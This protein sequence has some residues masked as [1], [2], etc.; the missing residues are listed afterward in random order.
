MPD[1]ISL[2]KGTN[3][4]VDTNIFFFHY[5]GRSVTCTAFMKRIAAGEIVAYVNTEILSDLLH[6]LMLQEAYQKGCI[7]E[8]RATLLRQWLA[9]DRN[10]C[11]SLVDYQTHFENTLA[12]GLRVLRIAR[13][14]LINSKLERANHGLMT[15][16]SIHLHNMRNHSVLINDIVTHDGDFH[17]ISDVTVW[18]PQDVIS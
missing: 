18:Q 7:R 5:C 14:H 4:F 13:K 8:S 9:R 6:K 1:L 10:N 3:V 12:M 2:P 16:D 17:H 11:K 15:N